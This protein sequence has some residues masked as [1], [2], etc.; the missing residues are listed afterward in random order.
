MPMLFSLQASASPCPQAN[1]LFF[2]NL[3]RRRIVHFDRRF[4]LQSAQRF[5]TSH[6]NFVPRLQSLCNFNVGHARD[7][8]FH[9]TEHGLLAVDD[10]NP[11]DLILLG[12]ASCNRRR[13]GQRNVALLLP[14]L[15][16][17][18]QILARTHRQRLDRNC[19]HTL[20]LGR[21]DFCRR[22]K[23]GPQIFRR[24]GQRHHNLKILRFLLPRPGF[25]R[26]PTQPPHNP[27]PPTPPPFPPPPSPPTPSH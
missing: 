11:L 20:L 1:S 23:A 13:R 10:K 18:V 3:L 16:R 19:N 5:G 12:V 21:F 8:G 14:A 7:A 9:G 2:F 26:P 24:T 22:R 27:L 15:R 6:Y 25:F 17:L 4:R